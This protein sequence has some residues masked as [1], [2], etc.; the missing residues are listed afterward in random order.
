M[1]AVHTAFAVLGCIPFVPLLWR[2][3]FLVERPLVCTSAYVLSQAPVTP[4]LVHTSMIATGG[5]TA[6]ALVGSLRNTCS[7]GP[8]L[9]IYG[10]GSLCTS[11]CGNCS[12]C[13]LCK[14]LNVLKKLWLESELVAVQA[15][16]IS[17]CQQNTC[18]TMRLLTEYL[19]CVRRVASGIPMDV[20]CTL[21][22]CGFP[23]YKSLGKV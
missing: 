12:F 23:N 18:C 9:V 4:Q 11:L 3:P 16:H 13:I 22:V 21:C 15:I 5:H 8:V 10:F 1:I 14:L 19:S 7:F 17:L 6:R 2:P 20:I